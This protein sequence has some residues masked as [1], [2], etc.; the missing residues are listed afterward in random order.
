MNDEIVN[1]QKEIISNVYKEID[2][3][4]EKKKEIEKEWDNKWYAYDD[5][6]KFIGYIER[7]QKRKA[8][9]NSFI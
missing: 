2:A 7:A 3:L 5:Q 6:V 1:Q 4:K 8:V 9:N